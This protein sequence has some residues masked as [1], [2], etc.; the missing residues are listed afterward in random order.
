MVIKILRTFAGRILDIKTTGHLEQIEFLESFLPRHK[1]KFSQNFE[2]NLHILKR[3]HMVDS[4]LIA[5]TDG[6]IMVSS[7]GNG[8]EEG[9]IGTSLLSFIKNEL[10]DSEA[11]LIK[12][13]E[14]WFMLM[15]SN[16][17]IIVVKAGSELSS[18]ELRA[19]SKELWGMLVSKKNDSP[20]KN[21]V[22]LSA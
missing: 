19:L 16:G 14:S 1:Y 8:H 17:K 20:I 3:K 22:F 7:E 13:N 4:F 12:R 15:P 21:K 2:E 6:S 5:D 9:M 18:I 11:V 10:P